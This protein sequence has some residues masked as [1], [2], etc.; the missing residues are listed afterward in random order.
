MKV[1]YV[2]QLPMRR[3]LLD[4]IL[5]R[6]VR[7]FVHDDDEFSWAS[8]DR[9]VE[10]AKKIWDAEEPKRIVTMDRHGYPFTTAYSGRGRPLWRR[11]EI[12]W[13]FGAMAREIAMNMRAGMN[14]SA[15]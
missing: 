6:P 5:D 1:I 10:S 3:T 14:R 9:A 8:R 11:S 13:A 12:R 2:I 15:R 4:R 7:W